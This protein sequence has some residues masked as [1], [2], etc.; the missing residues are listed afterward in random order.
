M[1]KWKLIL[2]EIQEMKKQ[3][4]TL[5]NAISSLEKDTVKNSIKVEE[6]QS[7]ALLIKATSFR[8]TGKSKN[9]VKT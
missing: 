3:R 8:K 4:L 9:N 7:F 2:A 6:K 5:Q 1:K